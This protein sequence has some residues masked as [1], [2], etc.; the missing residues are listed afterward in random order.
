MKKAL[1]TILLTLSATVYGSSFSIQGID[2]S[3]LNNESQAIHIA[4][5]ELINNP[6]SIYTKK[7]YLAVFP[8]SFTIFLNIFHPKDFGQLYDGF[9]YIQ[10]FKNAAA[11]H[12]EIAV[13]KYLSLASEACFD[14]DAPNHFREALKSFIKEHN[15]IYTKNYKL[16]T[17]EQQANIERFLK[18]SFHPHGNAEGFCN[19]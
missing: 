11:K 7:A 3:K 18:A 1:I 9:S 10:L 14:A 2:T 19:I 15:S 12:P 13:D 6:D 5:L 17:K 4:A 8:S 16:L